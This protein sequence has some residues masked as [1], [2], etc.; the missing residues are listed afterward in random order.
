MGSNGAAAAALPPL[1]P[2]AAQTLAAAPLA[3]QTTTAVS[4]SATGTLE[5]DLASLTWLNLT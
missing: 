1:A 4:V 3:T 5:A 2:V